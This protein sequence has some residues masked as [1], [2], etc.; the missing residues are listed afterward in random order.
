MQDYHQIRAL[1]RKQALAAAEKGKALRLEAQDLKQR[2][3]GKEAH[4]VN[5]HRRD[6]RPTR[7]GLHLAYCYWR[8][9]TYAQCERKVE[10]VSPWTQRYRTDLLVGSMLRAF[11]TDGKDAKMK[12]LLEQWLK[13]RTITK[14]DQDNEEAARKA[15]LASCVAHYEHEAEQAERNAKKFRGAASMLS[16]KLEV[17]S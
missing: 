6:T 13:E 14:R 2:G 15:E 12:A 1:L 9:R 11:G 7:R 16:K 10:A 17:H 5:Q 8:G 4:H 3:C